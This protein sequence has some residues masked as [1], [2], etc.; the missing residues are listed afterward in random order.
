M[1][2]ALISNIAPSTC[3]RMRMRPVRTR[4]TDFFQFN[5][6]CR[7][8]FYWCGEIFR[9]AL[10][11]RGADPPMGP[12]YYSPATPLFALLW[13]FHDFAHRG[14]GSCPLVQDGVYLLRD[15]Q[16]NFTFAS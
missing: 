10:Q 9:M 15:R 1:G 13:A 5:S 12:R 16:I 2:R 6:I 4:S 8:L 11:G 14:R 3:H 7:F